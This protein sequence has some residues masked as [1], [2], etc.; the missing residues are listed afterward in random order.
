MTHAELRNLRIEAG[1]PQFDLS[2]RSGV[3]R[4]RLSLYECGHV[5]L[6]DAEVQALERALPEL[7]EERADRLL[8]VLSSMGG[9]R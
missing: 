4:S 8:E 9:L 2:K 3:E 5:S 1:I 7:I 6:P